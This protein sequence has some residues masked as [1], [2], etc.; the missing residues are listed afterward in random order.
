MSNDW[1]L[2]CIFWSSM[3]YVFIILYKQK[4][5]FNH[6]PIR[7]CYIAINLYVTL[8]LKVTHTVQGCDWPSYWTQHPEKTFLPARADSPLK[9]KPRLTFSV[10]VRPWPHSDIRIC[11]P[12]FWNQNILR[13]WARGPSGALVGLQ[14]SH[15]FDMGHKGP[16]NE[17]LG[18]SGPWGPVPTYNQSLN[19]SR[20]RRWW[21][22]LNYEI[23]CFAV[24]FLTA[25][26]KTKL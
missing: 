17:G 5:V 4:F 8:R 23:S 9:R 6:F 24:T 3:F 12:F 20:T 1:Y 7:F 19:Q 18:A 14:G 25:R 15:D 26:S 13:V 16:I 11:A 10:N 2:N 21:V 22:L